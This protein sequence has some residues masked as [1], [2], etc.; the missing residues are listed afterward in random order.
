MSKNL[1]D[2]YFDFG[3]SK[4]RA[5]AFDKRNTKKNYFTENSC[6]SNL[7]INQIDFSKS[8]EIIEKTILEIE[9]KT[10]EYVD[11]VNLMIDSPDVLPISLSLSK[12]LEGSK[13]KKEEIQYIIQDAKQQIIRSYPDNNIIHII[14]TNYKVNNVNYESIPLNI[15][16]QNLSMDIVFIC[17]PKKLIKDLEE[18]FYKFNVT[19]NQFYFSSYVKCLNYK[20]QMANFEKIVFID[21]GHVKTSII[22]WTKENFNFLKMIPVGS[23]HITKDIAKILNVDL[24][25]SE[26]AKLNFDKESNFLIDNNL[27]LDLIKKVIFA[28]IEEILELSIEFVKLNQVSN[29]L[30]QLKLILMGEGSKI[31]DNKFKEEISFNI[32]LDLLEEST[33]DICE[34]GLKLNKGF[35]KQEVVIIP[36]KQKKKGFF[37]RLFHFFK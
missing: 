13:L 8:S 3:S 2:I 14:V 9:K 16:C 26:E 37:V 20:E 5:A 27:S 32:D 10:G 15:D 29:G 18:L 31:L 25:K 33:L 28:R 11:E 36:K 35:N 6:L 17:F 7:K 21:I 23:H 19:I 12:K 24:N 22:L 34:S 30:G 4:I 1:F